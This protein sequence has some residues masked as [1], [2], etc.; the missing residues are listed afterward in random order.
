VRRFPYRTGVY[1]VGEPKGQFGFANRF[2]FMPFLSPTSYILGTMLV[3][4]RFRFCLLLEDP[5]MTVEKLRVLR[6]NTL[7]DNPPIGYH[8][9]EL[10]LEVEGRRLTI[11]FN[12]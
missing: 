9:E 11:K 7:V 10:Q 12:W 1:F 3:F 6:N 2:T 8:P 4:C 5:E